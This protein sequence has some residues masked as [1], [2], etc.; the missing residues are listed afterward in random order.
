M[1]ENKP[2]VKSD[3]VESPTIGKLIMALAK[4]QG[5]IKAA[6]KDTTN[7]YFKS[8]YA[9]LAS[10]W[11][12]CR[13]PL[14]KNGLAVIQRPNP[15]NGDTISLTTILAHE[16]GEWIRGTLIMRPVKNDPQGLG[17]CLTYA[18]RYAL[19]AMVGICSEEDD[20]GNAGSGKSHAQGPQR[21]T[22]PTK[23]ELEAK[24]KEAKERFN[25][26]HTDMGPMAPKDA[27]TQ[28]QAA[29]A[30]NSEAV[31]M[32]CKGPVLWATK[33]NAYGWQSYA[34]GGQQFES[35]KDKMFQSK[36]PAIKKML[37][38]MIQAPEQPVLSWQYTETPWE[39]GE[40]HGINIAIVSVAVDEVSKI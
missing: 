30:G 12:A 31:T 8:K 2:E 4:A 17:S 23:E 24:A 19:S 20:D 37:N 28:A 3:P 9:D 39:K 7:T 32:F 16:S 33:E 26:K 5:L 21:D 6:P 11:E 13:E 14:A 27:P 29:P 18:R 38:D 36:D 35:G 22:E 10:V 25:S 15:T 34:V 1:E 40:K